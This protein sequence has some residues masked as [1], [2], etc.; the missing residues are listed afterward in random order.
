MRAVGLNFRDVLNVLGAYPGDP[1]PPGSDCAATVA[2]LGGTFAHLQIGGAVLGEAATGSLASVAR[3]DGRLTASIDG[4]LSF[5]QACTL[6]TTW[7]TV[8]MSLLA[9]E[10]VGWDRRAA[11]RRRGRRRPRRR[12]VLALA[13]PASRP[14]SA[15]RTSTFTCSHGPRRPH[16]QLARRR[17]LR[18]SAPRRCCASSRCG[19]CST[20]CPWTSS[21]APSR[22]SAS[23]AASARLASGRC[24]AT[25][26]CLRHGPCVQYDVVALDSAMAVSPPWM[27]SVLRLLSARA[28]AGVLHGLPLQTFRAREER[29]GRLPHAAGRHQHGQGGGAHPEDGADAAA[30]RPP[31]LGRD[32]RPR[33]GHGQVAR[34]ERRRVGRAGGPR[35]QGGSRGWREAAEGGEVRASAW[36]GATRPS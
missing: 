9:R 32:R 24:G 27:N 36:S 7:S 15:G 33:P 25:P 3:S 4:S 29:L 5:E 13:A 35:R 31:A 8:H 11:A 30:R 20:A 28:A 16:A 17:R 21:P 23:R 19:G 22:S 2:R 10:T 6:P 14:A 26:A 1:G 12:R 18:R 34:R